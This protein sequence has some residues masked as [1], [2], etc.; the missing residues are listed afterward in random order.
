MQRPK[1]SACA[2]WTRNRCSWSRPIIPLGLCRGRPYR[3]LALRAPAHALRSGRGAG[4]AR[5][6]GRGGAASHQRPFGRA[7]GSAAV[8]NGKHQLPAERQA[9]QVLRC[10]ASW[11]SEQIRDGDGGG[12]PG[13][14]GPEVGAG[15]PVGVPCHTERVHGKSNAAFGL[16]RLGW[17][18]TRTTFKPDE[19]HRAE[20]RT[21]RCS[22]GGTRGCPARV[23]T[24]SCGTRRG[25]GIGT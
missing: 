2:L 16:S 8:Q 12:R 7:Q 15:R 23:S 22:H 13:R 14:D 20:R 5:A 9:A 18:E 1:S 6:G 21:L 3:L 10:M 25:F 19:A 24:D 17:P 11:G 4:Y